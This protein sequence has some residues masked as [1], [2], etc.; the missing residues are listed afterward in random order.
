[1]R[2]PRRQR[3]SRPTAWRKNSSVVVMVANTAIR[4]RG[5]STPSDTIRTATIQRRV[6]FENSSMRADAPSSSERTTVV[7]SPVSSSRMSA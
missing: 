5:M 6:L 1:V 4:S 7:G 2:A 3:T